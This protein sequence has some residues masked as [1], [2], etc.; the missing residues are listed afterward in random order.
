MNVALSTAMTGISAANERLRASAAN[1]ASMSATNQSRE[2]VEP[3]N[4]D[5][6]PA[7]EINPANE[8]VE[9]QS[10]AYAFVANLKVLQTQLN[11]TGALLDIKA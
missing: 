5:K 1:I 10:A 11:T 9:Q 6:V 8:I 7:R 3:T 4:V 2:T